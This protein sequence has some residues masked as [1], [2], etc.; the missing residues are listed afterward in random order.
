MPILKSEMSPEQWAEHLR[1]N[2]EWRKNNLEAQKAAR[3]EYN[4]RP[5]VKA[6]RRERDASPQARASRTAREADEAYRAERRAIQTAL[7]TVAPEKHARRLALQTNARTGF[8]P[9]LIESM[10]TLQ[11]RQCA[12]CRRPFGPKV[13]HCADHCHD[14]GAPRGLLCRQCNMVEG[15]IKSTGLSPSDFG[16]RL[17]DYLTN[18]PFLW[19]VKP[20]G[21]Q[22]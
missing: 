16:K 12:V 4:A 18:P 22:C 17:A 13:R 5:E 15:L 3:R 11:D 1:L 6:K 10:L 20:L 2:R 14:V 9:A 7:K 21:P 8:T 19:P